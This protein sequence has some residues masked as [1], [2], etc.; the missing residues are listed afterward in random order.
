MVK[1]PSRHA[2]LLLAAASFV[3]VASL[4]AQQPSPVEIPAHA[5]EQGHPPAQKPEEAAPIERSSVTSHSMTLDGKPLHYT[6]TAGTLLIRNEEDKPYGSIFYTAYTEDG[7]DAKT[8]PVT[9]LYNG[10]PGSATL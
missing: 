6:A 4:Y 8:R 10:G 5:D 2:A 7:A 9:F 1:R 3:P